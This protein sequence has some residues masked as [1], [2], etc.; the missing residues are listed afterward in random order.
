MELD[1]VVIDAAQRSRGI[2]KMLYEFLLN[3]ALEELKKGDTEF[4]DYLT[5]FLDK[6]I[7][8]GTMAYHLGVTLLPMDPKTA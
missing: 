6:V 5:A 3:M 2:G 8:D 1:N 7:A 4:Q